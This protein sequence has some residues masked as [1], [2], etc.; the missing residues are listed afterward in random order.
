MNAA[1]ESLVATP[2]ATLAFRT[3]ATS[4]TAMSED[5]NM[6]TPSQTIANPDTMPD[7]RSDSDPSDSESKGSFR[8]PRY[9]LA[10]DPT[11]KIG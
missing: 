1:S 11:M 10:E 8:F 7:K 6:Q 5:N 4:Q 9:N 2:V 3:L